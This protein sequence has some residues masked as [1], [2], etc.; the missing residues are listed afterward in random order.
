MF[1]DFKELFQ[2]I[3]KEGKNL[4]CFA[5]IIWMVWFRRNALRIGSKPFPIHQVIPDVRAVQAE[6]RCATPP[7]LPDIT[8]R[9][10]QQ[11]SWKPPPRATLKVNFD[12]A[13][14]KDEN[15]VGVVS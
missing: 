3:I 12:G 4:E 8:N 13:L 6:Y 1:H 14:F 7:K 5:T 15:S 11:V 9:V 10:P 2:Y